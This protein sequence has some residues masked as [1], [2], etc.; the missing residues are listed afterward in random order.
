VLANFFNSLLSKKS[1]A[2]GAQVGVKPT[3]R[4]AVSRDAAAELDRI[5]TKKPVSPGPASN[6]SSTS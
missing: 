5:R 2:P 4:A 6:D 1:G 3:D